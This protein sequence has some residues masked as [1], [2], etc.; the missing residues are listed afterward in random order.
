MSSIFS[1]KKALRHQFS[2]LTFT[3]LATAIN[4]S[5]AKLI[6]KFR[7]AGHI[8]YIDN[9]LDADIAVLLV[10]PDADSTDPAYRL[11]WIKM[12]S[13]R[14]MNYG[15]SF[16]PAMEFDPGTSIFIYTMTVPTSGSI[17][18]STWG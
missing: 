13:D 14:V 4:A 15:A 16:T 1:G 11:L 8:A 9:T 17:Y 6:H 5:T 2:E 12:G 18:L 3:N 7:H 10:H